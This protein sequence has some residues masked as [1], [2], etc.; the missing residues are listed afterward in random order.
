MTNEQI[1]QNYL[2]E[3]VKVDSALAEKY[4]A[5]KVP[6]CIKAI[7]SN[8]R[9]IAV[10]STAMVKS[11]TVFKWARD[12]FIDGEFEATKAD[13]EITEASGSEKNVTAGISSADMAKAIA[14][15]EARAKAEA[16]KKAEEAALKKAAEKAAKEREKI[17]AKA[18]AEEEQT[19]FLSLL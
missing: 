15:A 1:I 3:Q 11:E 7:I 8:A 19:N 10:K 13:N 18:K 12:F 2:E 16:K 14:E 9:K 4:D 6:D 5:N 17:A